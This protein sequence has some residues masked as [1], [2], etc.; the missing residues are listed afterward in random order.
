[1]RCKTL[2]F[3]AAL[4]SLGITA[5]A[6]AG[7]LV[8]TLSNA[9]LPGNGFI[10]QSIAGGIYAQS[11]VTDSTGINEVEFLLTNSTATT[12]SV[13]VTLRADNGSDKPATTALNTLAT[14]NAASLPVGSVSTFD[15]SNLGIT[16]LTINTRYWIEITH[17]AGSTPSTATEMTTSPTALGDVATGSTSI[18]Q[19]ATNLDNNGTDTTSKYMALCVSDDNSCSVVNTA[20]FVDGLPTPEPAGIA[21]LGVGLIFLGAAR[22][23]ASTRAV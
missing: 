12:G 17:G 21:V 13:V 19:S 14:I 7:Y 8:N 9:T 23:R 18:F 5:S 2:P 10:S 1:M 6:H 4:L 16:G 20:S 15:Y 3:V 11:F 22:Y